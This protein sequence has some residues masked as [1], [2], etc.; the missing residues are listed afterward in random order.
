MPELKIGIG[1][2]F[3]QD[4]DSLR[5]LLQSL[6]SYPIDRIIAMDGRY[7]GH[8]GKEPLSD[9]KT[10]DLFKTIQTPVTLVDAP[11]SS[12]IVK[13]SLYFSECKL[14]DIDVIIVM[15]SDEYIIHDK[16][17]WPRFMQELEEHIAMNKDTYIQAYT[18]PLLI[19]Q[20]GQ[21]YP[22]NHLINS[23]RVFHRPWEL[24]YV[25]NHFTV[26]NKKTGVNM[27]YQ[28]ATTKLEH[29]TI[30]TDHKLRAAEY[31]QQREMYEWYQYTDEESEANKKRRV[32]AFITQRDK[33]LNDSIRTS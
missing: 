27:G 8:S 10:R 16:T 13:R 4:F 26:R 3:Y 9:K 18:I 22:P 17:S 31:M 29:L 28:T 23:A 7:K 21:R 20:K 6:Q 11:D 19:N 12:Q 14:F 24:Q 33:Q 5:R 15:D 1:L 25:D 2:S 30:G 32:D